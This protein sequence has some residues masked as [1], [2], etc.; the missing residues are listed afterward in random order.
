MKKK[1][2]V[3]AIAIAR[4]NVENILTDSTSTTNFTNTVKESLS[5]YPNPQLKI[6]DRTEE[7]LAIITF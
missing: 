5:S 6:K 7:A 1:Y 4:F 3:P 2:N